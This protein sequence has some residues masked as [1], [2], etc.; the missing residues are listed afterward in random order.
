MKDG[1]GIGRTI[2]VREELPILMCFVKIKLLNIC[3]VF[4]RFGC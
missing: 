3:M 4:L 1:N 2:F